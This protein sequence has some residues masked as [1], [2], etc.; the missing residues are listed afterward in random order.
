M[1]AGVYIGK[2]LNRWSN[3]H[4]EDLVQLYAL[5]LEKAPTAS[6][7]YA[8]NGEASY[9]EIAAYVSQTLGFDGKIIFWNV[10]EALAELGDWA[11]YALGSNSRVKAVHARNLLGWKPNGIS[12]KDWIALQKK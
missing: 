6:Y 4:I 10:D 3:V 12:L 8:E 2:G 9:G 5:A 1:G 7:F 11:K